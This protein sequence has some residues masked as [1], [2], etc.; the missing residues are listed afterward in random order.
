MKGRQ[1][2]KKSVDNTAGPSRRDD[3]SDDDDSRYNQREDTPSLT[4][5]EL[6]SYAA[7]W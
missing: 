5:E 2:G 1:L 7:G 3:D 6:G 4:L